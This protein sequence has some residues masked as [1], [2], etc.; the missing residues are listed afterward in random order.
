[1]LDRSS[2]LISRGQPYLLAQIKG[3]TTDGSK[4]LLAAV[5]GKADAPN[6]KT[7][8][9]L[10]TALKREMNEELGLSSNRFAVSPFF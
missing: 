3:N 6:L 10:M 7:P 4:L 5:A 9:S 1:M 8:D 2:R